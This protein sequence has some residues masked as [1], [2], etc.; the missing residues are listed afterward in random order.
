MGKAVLYQRYEYGT[1]TGTSKLNNSGGSFGASP[2]FVAVNSDN[3]TRL[4]ITNLP[5][6]MTAGGM[7]YITEIYTRHPLI[8]PLNNFRRDDPAVTV[9][10]GL[11]L[12]FG[13]R[14]PLFLRKGQWK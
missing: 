11:F 6:T 14:A 13:G 3:D 4:Q 12:M 1:F 2:E 7:L 9:F 8:T 10:G 5:M